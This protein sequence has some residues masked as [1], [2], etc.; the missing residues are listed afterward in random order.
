MVVPLFSMRIAVIIVVNQ[1]HLAGLVILPNVLVI[2]TT[3]LL[4]GSGVMLI[5]FTN[6]IDS[7]EERSWVVMRPFGKIRHGVR[8]V[9]VLQT[10]GTTWIVVAKT[11]SVIVRRMS[12]I[13][14]F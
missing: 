6:P 9:F 1:A 8:I 4:I 11:R 7:V 3:S 5:T 10:L 14:F 12:S 13:A 2:I